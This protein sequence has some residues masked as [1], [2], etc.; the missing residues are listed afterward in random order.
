MEVGM[1]R[2]SRQK[3]DASGWDWTDRKNRT[4]RIGGPPKPGEGKWIKKR[5]ARQRRREPIPRDDDDAEPI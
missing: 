5:L 1:R 2:S 3:T 4:R